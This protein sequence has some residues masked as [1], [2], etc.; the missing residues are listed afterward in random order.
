MG[1]LTIQGRQ[2]TNFFLQLDF[3]KK[4]Y[5]LAF[6]DLRLKLL[7]IKTMITCKLQGQSPN[8][9]YSMTTNMCSYSISKDVSSI[10]LCA[11][12]VLG[13]NTYHRYVETGFE[14]LSA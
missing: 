1:Q 5:Y 12:I 10:L 6:N 14:L 4:R 3:H 13:N 11:L 8:K 9:I 2:S 7:L